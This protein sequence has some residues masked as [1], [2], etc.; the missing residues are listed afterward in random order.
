MNNHTSGQGPRVLVCQHGARHRYAVPRMLEKA[1]ILTAFYTD[2]SAS[3]FL[4]HVSALFGSAAPNSMRRLTK[5]TIKGLPA[6]KVFSTDKQ[7]L[8]ELYQEMAGRLPTGISLYCQRHKILSKKMIAWG[9][10][11]AGIIYSMY[12]ENL[13]F[14][15]WAKQQGAKSVVDVFINPET[16][17]IMQHEG[18]RFPSWVQNTDQEAF[19]FENQLWQE[20]A[21]LADILLCPSEW[22]AEGVRRCSPD[23]TSKIK[24][25]PY[26]CSIDYL[27]RV[28]TPVKGR[29]LFAGG[30]ALRKGLHYLGEA[31]SN[32]KNRIPELDIR[33]AGSLPANVVQH[34]V[35]S[36]LNF[37]GKLTFEQMKEEY[38]SAD[39]FVLPSLSEGFA[40]VVAEA[41]GAGCPVIVT[42]EAGSPVV[43]NREGLVVP[44]R[45]VGALT[46]AIEKIVTNRS[47]RSACSANCLKQISF[48]S[49]D[50]WQKRLV[51]ILENC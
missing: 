15:R 42:K 26:G 22:V 45:D 20:T 21:E 35:C 1:G 47:L 6:D 13:D 11:G 38:L 5:R 30:D 48:Y 43:P 4:G 34:P 3:S 27:G 51:Y 49:E 40:G 46:I 28:N 31:S 41:I 44:S 29:V 24:I 7:Y 18:E 10:G 12:H 14:I 16:T 39:V 32:L 23:A 17:E 37:L 19:E 50:Q 9:A 2:S 36:G 33:I 25:V 8:R